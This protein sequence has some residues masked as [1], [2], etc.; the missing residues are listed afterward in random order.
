G[1]ASGSLTLRD[2]FLVSDGLRV[3]ELSSGGSRAQGL[4]R[5]DKSVISVGGTALIGW[6][7]TGDPAG[8]AIAAFELTV[9]VLTTTG[10]IAIAPHFDAPLASGRL[11]LRNALAITQESLVIGD[12]GELIFE[13]AGPDRTDG[14]PQP[15]LYS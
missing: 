5:A 2:A 8:E 1:Q 7:G 13:I 4:V 11:E 15:G 14:N 12:G 3:G 10:D 9:S 6:N